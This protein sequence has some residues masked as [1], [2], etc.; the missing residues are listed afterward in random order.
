MDFLRDTHR[1]LAQL[2]ASPVAL[3][4]RAV[5]QSSRSVVRIDVAIAALQVKGHRS[6]IERELDRAGHSSDEI[7]GIFEIIGPQYHRVARI[8]DEYS[9]RFALTVVDMQHQNRGIKR[10]GSLLPRIRPEHADR[11][12]RMNLAPVIPDV[13]L[14]TPSSDARIHQTPRGFRNRSGDFL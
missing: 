9:Q 14:A 11:T 7:C 8:I 4:D 10:K 3:G 13:N 1:L 5:R 6:M 2:L 12:I